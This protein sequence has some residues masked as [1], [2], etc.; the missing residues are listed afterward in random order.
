M[1]IG[2]LSFRVDGSAAGERIHAS[3]GGV[4]TLKFSRFPIP[5]TPTKELAMDTKNIKTK[6]INANGLILAI[7]LGKY[8]SVVCAY[9]PAEPSW[10]VSSFTTN[11][12]ELRH[13]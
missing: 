12:E 4:V 9:E 13:G 6:S 11:R 8:K 7:D 10:Q 1:L 2:F 3:C 5:T